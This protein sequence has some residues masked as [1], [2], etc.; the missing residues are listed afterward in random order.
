MSI[1][2]RA[3]LIQNLKALRR[4]AVVENF[5]SPAAREL[6]RRAH[7]AAAGSPGAA[8]W[9]ALQEQPKRSSSALSLAASASDNF[10][11]T[12]F[13]IAAE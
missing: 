1:W 9:A 5:A 13:S 2:S 4:R 10:E 3:I 6:L 8:G 12:C 11:P 7:R